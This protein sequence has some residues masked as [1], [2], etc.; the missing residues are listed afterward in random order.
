MIRG[1]FTR[2]LW[3]G[4]RSVGA[5]C[6]VS[7][8][9]SGIDA[10]TADA[11]ASLAAISLERQRAFLEESSAEASRQSARLR[12]A[13]LD[14]LAH[15]FKTPLAVIQAASSGFL[16]TDRSRQLDEEL[17]AAIQIEVQHLS[18]LTTQAL[19]TAEMEDKQLKLRPEQILV[20]P[21]LD[22]DWS[23]FAQGLQDHPFVID[24]GVNGCTVWA[25]PQLLQLALSQFIDNAAK[26]TDPASPIMLQVKVTD[27]ETVF[28]VHNFGSYI[29]P[30]ERGKIFQ[31]FYRTSESR[32]RAHG[33]GIGLTVAKQIA[34]AHR[35]HVWLES[36]LH[37]G[38]TFYLGLP[39]I[40]RES[41]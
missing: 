23:R 11:I 37:V 3:L 34:E 29:P 27:S 4:S 25:D 24:P 26:Y 13:V 28:S 20:K 2:I 1:K 21:F 14:G 8:T 31:R 40:T 41:R 18:D 36:D 6:V 10:R 30:Q 22:A 7:G 9:G 15:A 19:L 16:Q 12:S 33:T 5:L 35:G 32:Y 17:I 39:R 38:T